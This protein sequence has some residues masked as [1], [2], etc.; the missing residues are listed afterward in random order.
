[1]SSR[2][3]R[4]LYDSSS[5]E[6]GRNAAKSSARRHKP[7]YWILI[8]TS[9]LLVIGLVVVYS[10]SPGLAASLHV[11]Q[12]YFITKQLIDVGLGLGIFAVAAYLPSSWWWRSAKPLAIVA[13][14]GSLVVMFTP[15][16]AVYQA[17]RWIR[18]GGFS[19]QI[20]ELIKLALLTYMARFLSMQWQAGKIADFKETF[21]PLLILLIAVGLVVAKF[22]SDLGS[23]GV[24]VAMIVLMVFAVGVPLK[25]VAMI[26]ALVLVLLVLAISS[27][28]Y[29]RERLATFLHPQSNCQG[30][31]Y[32]ACQ[33]LIAVGSGGIFGLGLGYSVQAYGYLPEASN[34]SIFA[35]MAEKFGFIGTVAIVV[36]YG[37]FIA[38]LKRIIEHTQDQF[39]RLLVVGVLAWLS[40]QMIINIGAMLGLLPLKGITL[41][42]ISQGGTSLIFLMAALGL[43]FQISRYTSYS[44]SEPETSVRQQSNNYYNP[45]GRRL[46]RA[47]SAPATTR[48]RT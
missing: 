25:K 22:Q 11:S 13:I 4:R 16:D 36:V 47:H 38:R 27:S 40:T 32:Q 10:I 12:G 30:N 33:A 37:A 3:R 17:H 19:F 21:Q 7:D 31:G 24:M 9:L 8:L 20:A 41:P 29:R 23:T 48:P 15:I 26:S 42:L 34:D 43:V 35:I 28:A 5:T 39:K 44:K 6:G 1:M 18:L 45:N 46:G 14:V 2:P